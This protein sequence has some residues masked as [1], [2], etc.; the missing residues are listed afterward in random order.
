ME[1]SEQ[2]RPSRLFPAV[3]ASMLGGLLLPQAEAVA[4]GTAPTG[5][6]EPPAG[7]VETALAGE[8][9]GEAGAGQESPK[10]ALAEEPRA[11]AAPGQEAEE[12]EGEGDEG[13]EG[14]GAEETEDEREDPAPDA[15][16]D[17]VLSKLLKPRVLIDR[18]LFSMETSGKLQV[19]FFD[20][21]SDDPD[22]EDDLFI[23]RLRPSFLGHIGKRWKWKFEVELGADIEAGGIDLEQLD[24]RDMFVRYAGSEI[25]GWRL[26]LGNQW[27][28]FSREFLTPGTHL[29]KVERSFVGSNNGGVPDW[30]LGIHFRGEARE[31]R[32]AFWASLGVVGHV[33]GA[34]QMK[35]ASVF[36]AGSDLNE[37]NLVAA[38]LD[39][40]PRGPMTFFDSDPHTPVLKTTWSLAAYA[41]EN[42]GSNNRFTSGGVAVD[43]LKAD[44]DSATGFEASGGLRGRGITLDW[45]LN[46]I[47][48]E[49]VAEGFTGGIYVDGVTHVDSAAIEGGYR[50]RGTPLELGGALERIERDGSSDAWDKATLAVN[51]YG[52]WLL[53]KV[54]ISH[55][56][57]S[58]RFGVSGADF[59]ETRVQAEYR[60]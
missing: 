13:D 15:L 47:R 32:L 35:F 23:R 27:A 52:W 26:T 1:P 2:R 4:G 34:D 36:G 28:P 58:S 53:G 45:Q 5:S 10:P 54:Q 37:G 20:A 48:G 14:E 6:A 8:P 22:N 39:F 12:E 18:P 33:P 21:D 60:W 7:S 42:D 59:R 17:P 50:I 57:V 3:L 16:R 31:G 24:I 29:L 40:H 41:W 25:R 30:T 51:V 56:W 19:Q 44:L 38:R 11:E 55:T 46:L 43:P 49:T 9:R